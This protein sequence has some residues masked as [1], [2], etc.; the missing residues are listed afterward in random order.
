MADQ[1]I[2]NN[3][4]TGWFEALY[5]QAKGDSSA[6]P[7]ANLGP[8][9][10]VVDWFNKQQLQGN[11]QKALVVGCGLGDDAEF[12][13]HRGFVVTAFDVSPTAI[14]W[15]KQRFPDSTVT[16]H[17]ADLFEP[18]AEWLAGF[19]FVLEYFTI[20]ALPPAMNKEA[21]SSHQ[22]IYYL[23]WHY[24]GQLYRSR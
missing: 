10:D 20:Q 13:S 9:P 5:N 21:H 22:Q 8:S 14:A 3:N 19:D 6:V 11:S 15:C 2:S 23:H 12:L 17:P 1:Y 16:Y 7:W 24:I 4:P 18:P